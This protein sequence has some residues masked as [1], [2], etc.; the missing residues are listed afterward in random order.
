MS[1]CKRIPIRSRARLGVGAVAAVTMLAGAVHADLSV[2]LTAAGGRG[3]LRVGEA[4]P[5]GVTVTNPDPA[6]TQIL[7]PNLE[8]T[9]PSGLRFRIRA[10]NEA[11]FR[12]ILMPA[13]RLGPFKS[14]TPPAADELPALVVPPNDSIQINVELCADFATPRG[15]PT[16]F[17]VPGNYKLQAVVLEMLAIPE[18]GTDVAVRFVRYESN[19][20]SVRAWPP[21]NAAEQ[22]AFQALT[23]LPDPYLVYAPEAYQPDVHGRAGAA[24]AAFLRDRPDTAWTDYVR[25][26]DAFIEVVDARR[27]RTGPEAED[28]G[29]ATLQALREQPGFALRRKAAELLQRLQT[30][31]DADAEALGEQEPAPRAG[32]AD[33]GLPTSPETEAAVREVV[34]GFA[35]GF[36]RAD[37]AACVEWLADDFVYRDVLD[38]AAFTAELDED[39]RRLQAMPDAQLQWRVERVVRTAQGV[40]ADVIHTWS[41][42]PEEPDTVR[43]EVWGFVADAAGTWRLRAIRCAGVEETGE[44]TPR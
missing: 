32:V 42:A 10:P 26:A 6:P 11:G 20:L 13:Y 23:D 17:P 25:M 34:E 22:R 14:S 21:A 43:R 4:W 40:V 41:V 9:G 38:R 2:R 33:A 29:L 37:V 19:V 7:A 18:R 15:S 3:Q 39:M 30:P 35:A 36:R 44:A 5:V 24:I 8:G 1:T 31:A 28:A 27:G 16:L 12:P